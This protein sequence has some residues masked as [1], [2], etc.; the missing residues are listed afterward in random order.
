MDGRVEWEAVCAFGPQLTLV[1]G[2]EDELC[3]EDV[4]ALSPSR[5]TLVGFGRG[6]RVVTFEF[7]LRQL[8]VE[9]RIH[10]MYPLLWRW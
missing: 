1:D 5:H 9:L 8:R 4:N 10:H 6:R 3:I 7:E 2:D